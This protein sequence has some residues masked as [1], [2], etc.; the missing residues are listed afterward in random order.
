[1]EGERKQISVLF[2]DVQGSMELAERLDPESWRELM[3]RFFQILADAVHHADGTVDKFT[4]DGIMALFGAPIAREDHA[5]CACRAALEMIDGVAALAAEVS[6]DGIDLAVRIGINSGEVVVGSIGDQGE[7]EYTA[8]G[9]TVGLA[10]RME[11]LAETG[12]AYLTAS[13]ASLVE[14]YFELSPLGEHE[15]RGASTPLSLFRLERAGD[16]HGRL[17][18]SRSRG[19]SSFVGRAAEVGELE[20]AF[21]RSLSGTGEVVGIVAAAGVGKSRLCHEFVD[22]CR[23]RGIAVY[24]TQ[25]Q[26]HTK[27]I[28]LVP[29]LDLLRDRFGITAV[30]SDADA[31]AKIRNELT[32]MGIGPGMDED[33]GILLDFL[34]V[35]D[36]GAP[37]IQMKGDARNRRLRDMIRGLVQA[38]NRDPSVVLIEDLQWVD[39]AS[40]VFLE[41]LIETIPSSGGLVVVN[42]RPGYH[43]DW[44]SGAHYRQLPLSPLRQDSLHTLLHELLGPDASLDGL[45]ELISERTGG[46]PFYVEEVVREL[47]ESGTLAGERRGVPD[48]PRDRRAAGAADGAGG[49]CRSDRPALARKPR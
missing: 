16:A 4:G 48:G 41:T 28:P 40:E 14:G 3:N 34:G 10:Q 6:A 13:T 44:M 35:Q 9:H 5:Q 43:A 24:Q 47:A 25:C 39:P 49:T 31:Q 8:V 45:A 46:N 1:M 32:E 29:V 12:S 22:R 15:V 2:A 17:D 20:A 18:V 7:M 38:T 11:T 30:D 23:S 33:I 21:E 36:P 19:L 27:E 42:F 37:A 26:A